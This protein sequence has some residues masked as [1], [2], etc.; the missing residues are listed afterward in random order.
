MVLCL[1]AGV[2]AFASASPAGAQ[3][4]QCTTNTYGDAPTAKQNY[5]SDCGRPFEETWEFRCDWVPGGWQCSGPGSRTDA[6]VSAPTPTTP[7]T[8]AA[9]APAAPSAVTA[10]SGTCADG[11]GGVYGDAPTAKRNYASDCGRPFEETWEFRC[12]WVPG[13]WQCSGPVEA[14]NPTVAS[15]SPTTVP[16]TAAP[17]PP[18]PVST[19]DPAPAPA[20]SLDAPRNLRYQ[21]RL[22]VGL[23]GFVEWDAVDGAAKYNVYVDGDYSSTVSGTSIQVAPLARRT[24]EI[25]SVNADASVFS[26]KSQPL[27]TDGSFFQGDLEDL[28]APAHL[29]ATTTPTSVQLRWDG[30]PFAEGYDV[31]RNGTYVRSVTSTTTSFTT[32]TLA[33]YEVAAW[34][35]LSNGEQTHSPKGAAVSAAGGKNAS[36]FGHS[37]SGKDVAPEIVMAAF[38]EDNDVLIAWEQVD[39]PEAD[40]YRVFRD[41]ELIA[42]TTRGYVVDRNWSANSRY[43]VAGADGVDLDVSAGVTPPAQANTPNVVAAPVDRDTQ[44]AITHE[45]Q[46]VL[47]EISQFNDG[48]AIWNAYSMLTDIPGTIGGWIAGSGGPGDLPGALPE[49]RGERGPNFYTAQAM[50]LNYV[51]ASLG[52]PLL[53]GSYELPEDRGLGVDLDLYE[54]LDMQADLVRNAASAVADARSAAGGPLNPTVL[55]EVLEQEIRQAA[56][57]GIELDDARQEDGC[58]SFSCETPVYSFNPEDNSGGSQ[59]SL[60]PHPETGELVPELANQNDTDGDGTPDVLDDDLDGDGTPNVL[61]E[62]PLDDSKSGVDIT[63]TDGDGIRDVVDLDDDNDGTGDAV[64]IDPLDPDRD[65]IDGDGNGIPDDQEDDDEDDDPFDFLDPDWTPDPDCDGGLD[66]AESCD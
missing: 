21:S 4:S 7:P 1:L 34:I 5:A 2:L 6:P 10:D 32:T 8:T 60:V 27:V 61:D 62:A 49:F 38:T 35:K 51:M 18:T 45:Y 29:W 23:L 59:M 36:V 12:D 63:D 28:A 39:S 50:E 55:R 19:P 13:G 40:R 11:V 53:V 31:Y 3:T 54:Q 46:D 58:S 20:A 64:D 9:P 66:E 24:Y 42:T 56:Y 41:G 33:T 65:E 48:A 37:R 30:V 57:N 25:V 16:T 17:T 26:P 47:A 14:S 52:S 43:H 15:H 22:M 44:Y